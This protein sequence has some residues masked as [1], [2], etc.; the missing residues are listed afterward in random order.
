MERF[1][2]ISPDGRYFFFA[3]NLPEAHGEFFWVDAKVI[4][5]LRLS[6]WHGDTGR[7]GTGW[8]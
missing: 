2:S 5:L 1:P 4:E 3:R 6:S 7:R 8:N